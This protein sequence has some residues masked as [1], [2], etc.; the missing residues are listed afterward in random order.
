MRYKIIC[1]ND[2]TVD[3]D[4]YE[5]KLDYCE[6][7]DAIMGDEE[8]EKILLWKHDVVAVCKRFDKEEETKD[9]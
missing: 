9:E 5:L 4:T 6:C 3:C 1:T 7:Y 8:F 2:V